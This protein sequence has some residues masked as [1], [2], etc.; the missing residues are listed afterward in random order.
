M[1][2]VPRFDSVAHV[3]EALE[4]AGFICSPVIATVV[5]LAQATHKPVLGEG[6][7]G[8]G[9]TELAK[10]VARCLNRELIRLQ[11]YEGLDE[12]KA[13]Y[14]WEYAK[15]LL[16][17]QMVKEKIN[18]VIAGARSI[19]EAVDRIAAQEDAFFSERFIQPRP[20]LQAIS[21][22]RPVVLLIDEVDKSDPEFEAFLLEVLSDFQVSIPELGTRRARHI[23]SV[24]LTSNDSRDM[25][26]ALKRRCLH[27][28]I[29]YPDRDLELKIVQLKL[30]SIGER[31]TL[32]LVDAIRRIRAMD[33]K[34]K[35]AISETLDWAQALVALQVEDLSPEVLRETLNVI[36]KHR[37][38][39]QQV[40]EKIAKLFTDAPRIST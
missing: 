25:S 23:P 15:Q 39:V 8:V 10:A 40:S 37:S 16:Y 22:E 1:A 9:K 14:E 38:D 17:T 7:A 19:T 28:Y 30:P 18:D 11:C 24:F 35:P 6:P 21:A 12:A 4:G 5:F 31:L 34:K 26:D 20:L 2:T 36:C 3:R 13:L 27:L 33:L 29:D 32:Q